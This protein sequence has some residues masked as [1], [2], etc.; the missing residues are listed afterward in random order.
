[1]VA[2]REPRRL[3]GGAPDGA[4]KHPIEH[5]ANPRRAVIAIVVIKIITIFRS[6]IALQKLTQFQTLRRGKLEL[7]SGYRAPRALVAP[8]HAVERF[9]R[10]PVAQSPAQKVADQRRR[11]EVEGAIIVDE[12]RI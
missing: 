12:V 1:M 5:I 11:I 2:V 10:E 7:L 9:D 8:D 6:R 4:A 3:S